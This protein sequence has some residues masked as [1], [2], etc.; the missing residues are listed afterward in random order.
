MMLSVEKLS[1]YYG[2]IQA[3]KEV[4]LEVKEKEIVSVLGAN[5]AGKSTLLMSISGILPSRQG[6]VMFD[7]DDITRQS[8]SAIVRLG[9][10]Q[11]PEGR[12]VFKSLTTLDNLRMGTYHH[13]RKSPRS[14]IEEDLERV[15]T[16]F[17]ILKQ[18]QTQMAGTLSGGEQQM[19][20]I[21]RG[22]MARPKLMMLDE[23]SLGL[24]PLVVEEI[25]K[26]LAALNSMGITLLLIEQNARAALKI[27]TRGYVMETGKITME[28][29]A[30]DLLENEHVVSAYLGG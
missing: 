11:V 13:Y 12:D 1:V 3:L 7:K 8:P 4:S 5:G 17:P 26:T 30:E 2:A 10:S 25:F 21:G 20:A 16:L 24:A 18:R 29:K 19:L 9:I 28:G 14:L 22:L 15:F 6:K 23:P 27:A